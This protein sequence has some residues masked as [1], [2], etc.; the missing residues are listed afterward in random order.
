MRTKKEIFWQALYFACARWL[1]LSYHCRLA[2]K[3][4]GFYARRIAKHVGKNVNV[5]KGAN[6]SAELSLGDYSGIGVN[7]QINGPVTIGDYVMMGPD[8]VIYTQNHK[9]DDLSKPMQQAG[10]S[11]VKPVTIGNDVWIGAR[12]IILPGVTIGEGSVIGAGAVVSKDI[13]PYSVAVGNP[14]RVVKNRK[15][16]FGEEVNE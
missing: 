16:A 9:I 4:R 15:E 12:V 10:F 13:P 7:C 3:L 5:E 14:I 11:D 8:C 2:K 1:P 6:F